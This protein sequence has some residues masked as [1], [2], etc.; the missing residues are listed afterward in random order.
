MGNNSVKF[1]V[2]MSIYYKEKPENFKLALDSIFNQTMKPTEIILVEDGNLTDD[3]EK[4]I[5]EYEKKYS[6]FLVI[7]NKENKGLGYSLNDGLKKCHFN[8]IFR[9][10]TDDICRNDRFEKQ[11]QYMIDNPTIDVLGSNIFE[12]N[13]NIDEKMR[14][15]K[16]PVGE[17]VKKYILRRNPLNHMTVCFKKSSVEECGGYQP[18]DYLEDYYLWVRMHIAGKR[19]D[20]IDDTLVY[21]RIGNGFEKRRGNKKQ[22]SG[23]KK[24]Q[25]YMLENN[26]ID[27]KMYKKNIRNMLFMIY[28]PNFV[29]KLAYKYI[30]R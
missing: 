8:Y 4:V 24:M 7:R 26:L 22:I 15:K 14:I 9:M 13:E 1:S 30:L 16:M 11:I 2:L 29:R 21:A 17:E 23:W 27:K 12:F 25:N 3:L 28:C 19:I 5:K 10:D 20:N 18:M 6:N